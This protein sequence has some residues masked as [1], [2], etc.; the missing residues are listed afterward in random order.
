M[1]EKT[2]LEV[3]FGNNT[4]E[5]VL[6]YINTYREG[7]AAGMSKIFNIPL[8]MVQKQLRRFEEGGILVSQLKGNTRIFTFNPRYIFLDE[9]KNFLNKAMKLLPEK[10][11]KKYYR[12]RTRPRKTGKPL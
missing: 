1:K 2:M 11:I 6:L 9:L 7:Y 8:N 5:K 12:R 4:A 3:I 10:E